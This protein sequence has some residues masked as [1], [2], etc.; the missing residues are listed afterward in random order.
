MRIDI[1]VPTAGR[2]SLRV[3]L[4]ALAV[5]QPTLRAAAGPPPDPGTTSTRPPS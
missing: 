3:L 5:H 2:P 4:A 1:V